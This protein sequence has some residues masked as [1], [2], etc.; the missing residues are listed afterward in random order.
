M[1]ETKGDEPT[2]AWKKCLKCIC[3]PC[4]LLFYAIK[5]YC[6]GCLCMCANTCWQHLARCC[7]SIWECICCKCC[8]CTKQYT[9]KK[10]PPE[11][12]SV[13]PEDAK[14][15]EWRRLDELMSDE[16]HKP[17]LFEGPIEAKDVSQGQIGDCWLMSTIAA[18][19]EYPAVIRNLFITKRYSTYGK[20]TLQLWDGVAERWEEVP[21]D[22]YVPTRDGKNCLYARPNGNEMWAI[23]LEKA[24]AKFCGGFHNIDGGNTAWALNLLTGFPTFIMSECNTKGQRW[25]RLNMKAAGGEKRRDLKLNLTDEE[26]NVEDFFYILREYDE[27]G[28]L[29][30]CGTYPGKD[31]DKNA[32]GIVFGHA[33]TFI[34]ARKVKGKLMVRVRNPWGSGEWTGPWGPKSDM[35]QKHSDIAKE[36]EYDPKEKADGAFWMEMHDFVQNFRNVSVCVRNTGFEDLALDPHERFGGCGICV[37]CVTGCCYYWLCCGGCRALCCGQDASSKTVKGKRDSGMCS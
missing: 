23:L 2:P 30:C 18:L 1:P 20:Y 6:C 5:I 29:M 26:Y 12:S 25:S 22:N 31:T 35:W 3:C 16:G 24:V 4:I 9:D 14:K 17:Q 32:H 34:S 28:A 19:C 36:L 10:F 15:V 7:C 8:G 37:G 11:G 21:V 27:K 13:G 33:Y